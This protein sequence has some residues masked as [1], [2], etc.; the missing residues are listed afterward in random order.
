MDPQLLF[1]ALAVREEVIDPEQ[2]AAAL[3]HWSAHKDTPFARALLDRG[4]ISQADRSRLEHLV[5]V[6]LRKHGDNA[7]AG[8]SWLVRLGRRVRRRRTIFIGL[9]AL[10]LTAVVALALGL[11]LINRQRERAEA[12]FRLALGAVEHIVAQVSEDRL[13]NEPALQPLR[14]QLLQTARDF[15]ERFV[16]EN[17]TDPARQADL[18]RVLTMLGEITAEIDDPAKALAL[19]ERALGRFRYLE[20]S[21]PRNPGYRRGR[22]QCHLDVGT[23]T[24]SAGPARAEQEYKEALQ[25]YEALSREAPEDLALQARLAQCHNHLSQLYKG[26]GRQPEAVGQQDL[27]LAI[28]QRLV[29]REPDNSQ[30]LRDLAGSLSNRAALYA[31]QRDAKAALEA[32]RQALELRRRLVERH[33]H[34]FAD[35]EDL[36]Q[37][38]NDLGL[39][40]QEA[41]QYQEALHSFLECLRV[42]EK[43]VSGTPGLARFREQLAWTYTNL[44][45]L[46]KIRKQPAERDQAIQKAIALQEAL[47]DDFKQ[48]GTYAVSLAGL[49]LIAGYHAHY[50]DRHETALQWF[51]KVIR[52]LAPEGPDKLHDAGARPVARD[53]YWTRARSLNALKRPADALADYDHALTLDDGPNRTPLRLEHAQTLLQLNDHARAAAELDALAG[54]EKL[55][56]ELCFRLAVVYCRAAKAARGDDAL[57]EAK[58]KRRADDCRAKATD[59]LMR[60]E[61]QEFFQEEAN[62]KRAQEERDLEEVW[63]NGENGLGKWIIKK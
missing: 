27:A 5:E 1:A 3:A 2:F 14:K 60:A 36:G 39:R 24:S 44:A 61:K 49:Y 29:D 38:W 17:A 30:S 21:D 32:Q 15:D 59:L 35:Q 10:L 33:P 7:T 55:S 46:Y 41:R 62:R 23:L 12:N 53:A 63:S 16:D 43:L 4:W 20:E 50:E 25:L 13:L 19:Y 18:A 57:P 51:G 42:R 26:L 34:G 48:E 6:R 54:D 52:L 31:E 8:A 28:Q 45:E 56:G 37:S 47:H 9:G 22:A 11:L 58:R 40:L